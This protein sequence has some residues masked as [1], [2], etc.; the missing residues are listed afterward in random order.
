[1]KKI[2]ITGGTGF[3][4]SAIAK[5]L[6]DQW[7]MVVSFDNLS[8]SNRVLEDNGIDIFRGDVR[9]IKDFHRC[10]EKH[11]KFDALWH[12]AYINGTSSFYSNPDLVLEVGVKGAINTLDIALQHNIKEYVLISSSEVY[13]E[14]VNIPTTETE[15]MIIPD[16]Y[17]PRFSYS[18][19]KIISE[20]MTIHF[21]A[22]RGLNTKIFRPH[23]LFGPNMGEGHVIPQIIKKILLPQNLQYIDEK[24]VID[25]QGTGE[26]TRSFCYIDDAADE[27]ILASNNSSNETYNIGI[28]NEV[29]IL[30][31]VN[32]IAEILNIKITINPT[33]KLVGSANRRCPDMSKL[34]QLGFTPKYSLHDG[35]IKTVEWYKDYY[36]R[37]K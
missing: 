20:L 23:N 25:I 29:S 9:N 12:C 7:H 11:G 13:Q 19:G 15:R 3:I 8:R 26:E 21:G 35:L 28:Q 34:N 36:L 17:N 6:L 4:P 32:M 30:T 18:G 5:K 22:F 16:V 2:L 14:P 27:M 31:L 24:L 33:D 37:K 10:I 1:M